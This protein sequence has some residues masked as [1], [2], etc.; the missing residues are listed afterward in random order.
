MGSYGLSLL[1]YAKACIAT[2]TPQC[3]QN[4]LATCQTGSK[5][6]S[7]PPRQ[8]TG[9]APLTEQA[10]GLSTATAS[11]H[12][13]H[14]PEHGKDAATGTLGEEALKIKSYPPSMS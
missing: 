14:V 6:T 7:G 10:L 12:G 13:A 5:V 1:P 8:P 3:M 2:W 11:V 9:L 4:S